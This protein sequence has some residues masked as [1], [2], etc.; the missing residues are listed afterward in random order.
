MAKNPPPINDDDDDVP[1]WLKNAGFGGEKK[2]GGAQPTPPSKPGPA[3]R[4]SEPAS[5]PSDDEAMP[6]LK[7]VPQDQPGTPQHSGLTGTLPWRQGA[8]DPADKP[9]EN[10]PPAF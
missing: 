10:K 9:S 4:P 3:P 1:A 8:S 2:P 6:W 5:P 7:E